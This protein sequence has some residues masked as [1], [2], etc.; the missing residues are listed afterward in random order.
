M[1]TN[2]KL[3]GLS[4]PCEEI[5]EIM[6]RTPNWVLRW[7]ILVICFI[8]CALLIGSYFIRLPQTL[9]VVIYA[10]TDI[11]SDSVLAKTDG[12]IVSLIKCNSVTV[13]RGDTILSCSNDT[14]MSDIVS[15]LSGKISFSNNRS[16]GDKVK[17]G[18]VLFYVDVNKDDYQ[19]LSCYGFLSE[20]DAKQ[21]QRNMSVSIFAPESNDMGVIMAKVKS[22][23]SHP[24]AFGGYYMDIYLDK[25]NRDKLKCHL[26]NPITELDAQITVASPRLIEKFKLW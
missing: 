6:G 13:E 21:M 3:K 5:Q 9:P 15:P 8:V 24:N 18:E 14:C 4:T 23:A 25:K 19:L 7:G 22:I 2:D 17:T 12:N 16:V 20:G 11:Q 26:S 10:K 1:K